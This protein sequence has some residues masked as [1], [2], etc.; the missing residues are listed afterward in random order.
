MDKLYIIVLT[1]VA[2]IFFIAILF[3]IVKKAYQSKVRKKIGKAG[4]KKVAKIIR[5]FARKNKCKVINGAYLPLYNETCEIDHLVFGKFGV[6]IIETKNVGGRIEGDGKYLDHYIGSKKF[7]LYNPKLQNKTHVDNV[8]H[9]LLKQGF[10]N[11]QLHP[12]V[13]F[14]NEKTIIPDGLGIHA[15]ELYDTLKR[16]PKGNYDY[17]A[18]YKVI[19]S[20]RVKS[21]LKRL[22]HF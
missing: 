4:E 5:K 3:F 19:K 8:R 15:N 22:F 16:L 18:M 17:I 12:I 9:H 14:A 21:P 13:V 10:K 20:I 1:V 7:K 2:V 11:F 6:A